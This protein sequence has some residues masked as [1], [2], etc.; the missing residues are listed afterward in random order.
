VGLHRRSGPARLHHRAWRGRQR[1][2]FKTA[3]NFQQ[4]YKAKFNVEPSYQAAESAACGVAFQFALQ[5]A[6][7]IEPKAVRDA[8]AN[9]DVTTFYGRIKFDSTGSNT[10]KP[11]VTT[12]I[13]SG[14]VV[15]VFP[16][17]IANGKIQYSA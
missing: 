4:L 7:S 16:S 5:N 12:Q 1:D 8:L 10:T 17:D 2:V 13:Q 15:T 6:G 9:L 3:P 11:M 14:A